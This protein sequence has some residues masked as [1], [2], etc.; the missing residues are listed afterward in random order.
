MI[1][2]L[3]QR[4]AEQ[5]KIKVSLKSNSLGPL[6]NLTIQKKKSI[7]S[8]STDQSIITWNGEAYHFS[9]IH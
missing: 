9:K 1:N 2:K 7:T 3:T 6:S 4:E 5:I 8:L